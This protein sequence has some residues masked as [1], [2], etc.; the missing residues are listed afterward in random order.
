[1]SA[2]NGGRGFLFVNARRLLVQVKLYYAGVVALAGE[3]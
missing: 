3:W 2:Y 1:M